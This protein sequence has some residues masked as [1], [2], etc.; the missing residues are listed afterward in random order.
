MYAHRA[1]RNMGFIFKLNQMSGT[2]MSLVNTIQYKIQDTRILFPYHILTIE[3]NEIYIY[4]M[5]VKTK[6]QTNS[7]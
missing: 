1:S 4:T 5:S 3:Y 6:D 7:K 2:S